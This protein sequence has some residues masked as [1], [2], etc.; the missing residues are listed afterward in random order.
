MKASTFINEEQL[1]SKAIDALISK[2][3]PVETNRFLSLVKKKKVESVKRHHQW[4]AKLN[5]EQFFETIFK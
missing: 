4:Q 3:G 5:K 2:L 1:I